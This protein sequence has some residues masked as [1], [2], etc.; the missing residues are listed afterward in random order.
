MQ[1]TGN[2]GKLSRNSKVLSAYIR[3]HKARQGEREDVGIHGAKGLRL[4]LTSSKPP[5]WFVHYWLHRGTKRVHRAIRL[6][7]ARGDNLGVAIDR[8]RAIINAVEIDGRDPFIEMK[9]E[10]QAINRIHGMVTFGDLFEAWLESHAKKR[11]RSWGDEKRR[12]DLHLKGPLGSRPFKEIKRP[13]VA[14]VRDAVE[15]NAGPIQSNR[16]LALFN[17][18]ANWAVEEG[19]WEFNPANRMRKLGQERARE[20][21]LDDTELHHLWLGLADAPISESMCRSIKLLILVGQRRTEVIG[22]RLDELKDL[23]GVAPVW[24]IGSQ[25]TKNGLLHRVPLSPMAVAIFKQAID[26]AGVS[27][28][29]FKSPKTTSHLRGDAVTKALKRTCARLVIKGLGPHDLRRTVG[30][31]MARIG[32]SKDD[33]AL[34]LNHSRERRASVTTAVYDRYGYDSEKRKA[35][36]RWEEELRRIVG[37][38]GGA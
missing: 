20:R 19:H 29:I 6:G 17:R 1:R 36:L 35:L 7:E 31:M 8:A 21:V 18:V 13:E 37:L 3:E 26:D 16:V 34:V 27:P 33:R 5:Q 4:H 38:D 14:A 22:A 28:F 24:E 15:A 30:T 9:A 23:D 32:V 12:Y 25:R 11:L 2:D 10:L